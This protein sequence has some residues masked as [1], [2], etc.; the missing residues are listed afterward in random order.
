MRRNHIDCREE[1]PWHLG[2]ALCFDFVYYSGVSPF[3][4]AVSPCG[5]SCLFLFFPRL[6]L[7]SGAHSTRR[8]S[9]SVVTALRL[10]KFY[11]IFMRHKVV[12]KPTEE[13]RRGL[14]R[15]HSATEGKSLSESES[16][17]SHPCRTPASRRCSHVAGRS[18]SHPLVLA[19]PR[20]A[21]R[22]ESAGR[23]GRDDES[24][25]GVECSSPDEL[26]IE[27]RFVSC[28]V[29]NFRY[30][31][32][33]HER[34]TVSAERS[35]FFGTGSAFMDD[36]F[37]IETRDECGRDSPPVLCFQDQCHA[38]RQLEMAAMHRSRRSYAN[39]RIVM[40]YCLCRSRLNGVHWA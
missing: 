19:C 40:C 22:E 16:P 26:Y 34:N 28:L 38:P 9:R 14:D 2:V 5:C 32:L 20:G 37:R 21:R 7:P 31:F 4:P 8:R 39:R 3:S 1:R 29:K 25:Q 6:T 12:E 23:A 24:R 17:L 33:I 15:A 27:E 13:G 11:I 35:R 10:Y 18:G 30:V 36:A